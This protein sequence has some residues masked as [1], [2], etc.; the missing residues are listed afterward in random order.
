MFDAH[1]LRLDYGRARRT[2]R[3]P[4]PDV[5]VFLCPSEVEPAGRP[6][7]S[8]GLAGVTNY[9]FCMGDWFVWGGFRGPPNRAAFGPN[10]EPAVGRLHRRPEQHAVAV[11]GED[12]S[13]LLPRLRRA[14]ADQQPERRPRPGRR[15]LRRSP[16]STRAAVLQFDGSGHTEWIDGQVH[17]TGLHHRLDAEQADRRR[18]RGADARHRPHRP[19]REDGGPTFA[20]ITARS[21]HPGGVNALLGDGAVRFVKRRHQRADLAGPGHDRRRRGHRRRPRILTGDSD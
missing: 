8:V 1:Q 15:P 14:L 4:E 16:R 6:R 11:R 3:S 21:Y 5:A 10:R 9:G 13:A 19:A 2:S 7:T 18:R 17:H 20:A 12:L